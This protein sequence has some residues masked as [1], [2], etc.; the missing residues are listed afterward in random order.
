MQKKVT[1]QRRSSSP[2]KRGSSRKRELKRKTQKS[3]GG[4]LGLQSVHPP[5]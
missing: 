5:Q 4:I 3:V 2:A 1:P